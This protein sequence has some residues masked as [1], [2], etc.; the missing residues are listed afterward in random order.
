MRI[1]P[2]AIRN[3]FRIGFSEVEP[4][5][6]YGLLQSEGKYQASEQRMHFANYDVE[7]YAWYCVAVAVAFPA[8]MGSSL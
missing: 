7:E 1:D 8:D 2:S 4:S 6:G 3:I 5:R